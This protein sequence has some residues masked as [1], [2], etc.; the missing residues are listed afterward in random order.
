MQHS[1]DSSDRRK[2][3]AVMSLFESRAKEGRVGYRTEWPDEE[4]RLT[5]EEASAFFVGLML[6]LGQPAAR[7]W[8]AGQHL[9]ANHFKKGRRFSWQTLGETR[10]RT[11]RRIM[12]EGFDGGRPQSGCD[13]AGA[14][15]RYLC[16]PG[17]NRDWS[18]MAER[19]KSNARLITAKYGG[20]VRRVWADLDASEV[21]AIYHR[22][23]EFA[24]IG[25]ALAKMGQF[26]LAREYGAA[27]G[28]RSKKAMSVKPDVHINRVTHRLGLV[29]EPRA[30]TVV[31]ELAALDLDSPADF[32]LTVWHVGQQ[33]CTKTAPDCEGCPLRHACDHGRA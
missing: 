5:S 19:L 32:D 9:V 29:S 23:K 4:T 31:R 25:D 27:G 20:D 7:A 1:G 6:D 12:R 10:V 16:R 14:Y 30:R 28:E 33:F 3:R 11:I 22:L 8:C 24:G 17:G 13:H 15:H 2:V 18:D 21:D 26:A